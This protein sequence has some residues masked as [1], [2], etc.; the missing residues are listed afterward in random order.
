[1]HHRLKSK[2]SCYNKS[3]KKNRKNMSELRFGKDIK[4]DAKRAMYS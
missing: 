2:R 4:Y 1:M 3:E